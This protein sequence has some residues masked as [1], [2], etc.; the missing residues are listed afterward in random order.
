MTQGPPAI[1]AGLGSVVGLQTARVLARRGIA[2][3]GIASDLRHFGARTRVCERILEADVEGEGLPALLEAIRSEFADPPVLFPCT[4]GAVLSISEHRGRLEGGY[5]IA[6]PPHEVV[7]TLMRKADFAEHAQRHGLPIPRTFVLRGRD[8]AV[9]AARALTY[10]AVLKP[11]LKTPAWSRNT[12]AKALPVDTPEALLSTY[13]R[14]ARWTSALVAQEFVGGGD[15]QLFTCNTC[16]GAAGEPLVSFVTRKR[17]QWPPRVGIG[18][19][20][21]ECREDEVLD[22]TL[23]LFRSVEFRGL[24]YLEVKRDPASGTYRMIEANIGRPTGRSATAE[25]GGVEFLA[26]M[27]CD[28]AG[29]ALPAERRQRYVGAAWIDVRR[30]VLSAVHHW[31]R[32]ELTPV[33]WLRSFR[34]PTAHAVL[35]ARDPLPFMYEIGRSAGRAGARAASRLP[36]GRRNRRR[37]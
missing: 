13:D 34:G 12:T 18:S 2:V 29:L 24:G 23:R 36:V 30:D 3:I 14:V 11:S 20:A 5:R 35:S 9:A 32:G 25:A 4:D 28:T 37:P 10:P 22:L 33:D 19:Y 26:T 15:D 31:R 27:Y 8:E 16:F 7:Q 1:V 17:R 6:L 21:E